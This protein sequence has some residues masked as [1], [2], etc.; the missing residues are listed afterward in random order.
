MIQ[1]RIMDDRFFNEVVAHDEA[2]KL[3]AIF[4]VVP[5]WEND[6]RPAHIKLD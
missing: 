1:S 6:A 5:R 4:R 2:A 3:R